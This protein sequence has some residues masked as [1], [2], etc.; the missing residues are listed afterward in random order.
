MTKI[1]SVLINLLS[2]IEGYFSFHAPQLTLETVRLIKLR[3]ESEMSYCVGETPRWRLNTSIKFGF[4]NF[5][6]ISIKIGWREYEPNMQ[7]Y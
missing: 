4:L 6:N 2:F 3:R 7:I 1:T 5:G